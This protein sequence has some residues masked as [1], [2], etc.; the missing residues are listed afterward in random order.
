M[1]RVL[2]SMRFAPSVAT[3]ENK[4]LCFETSTPYVA[5]GPIVFTVSASR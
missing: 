5:E 3:L 4:T 2:P 1:H